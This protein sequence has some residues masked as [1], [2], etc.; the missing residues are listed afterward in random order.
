[1]AAKIIA[2]FADGRLYVKEDKLAEE[3]YDRSWG[4][5][6][7]IGLVKTVEEVISVDAWISGYRE[8]LNVPLGDVSI[9][10]NK[11]F[12]RMLRDDLGQILSGA[13]AGIPLGSGSLA[14]SVLSGLTS[15]MAYPGGEIQS[16]NVLVSGRVRV[17]A[18]V[19]GH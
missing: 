1:M 14:F 8:K 5:P 12:I 17:V 9:S 7:R 15:G 11:I 6:L 3:R 16:G 19:I 13:G 4:L 2:T 10:G 18:S